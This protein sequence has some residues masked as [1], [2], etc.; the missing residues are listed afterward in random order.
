MELKNKTKNLHEITEN[1]RFNQ[2]LMGGN[3]DTEA[4]SAYLSCQYTVFSEIERI[5]ELPHPD[6]YRSERIKK[7][8]SSRNSVCTSHEAAEQYALSITMHDRITEHEDEDIAPLVMP[9]VYLNYLALLYGGSMMKKKI[10]GTTYMFEFDNAKECIQ[11][12]RDIQK[13]DMYWIRSVNWGYSM[14][15]FIFDM[16][17]Q[18]YPEKA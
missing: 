17:Q 13:D 18:E 3:I 7:D 9:H 16:L 2:R 10:E 14:W 1:M 4:Y 12:I 6:L 11:S 5:V 8:L 15:I